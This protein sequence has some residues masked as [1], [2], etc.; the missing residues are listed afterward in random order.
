MNIC[1]IDSAIHVHHA[2]I[3]DWHSK[4]DLVRML[5]LKSTAS[6]TLFGTGVTA[7]HL[8]RSRPAD[9]SDFVLALATRRE[10]ELLLQADR[11]QVLCAQ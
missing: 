4:V 6:L 8:R 2:C 3:T 9:D 7:I 1:I 5:L 10:S 11:M